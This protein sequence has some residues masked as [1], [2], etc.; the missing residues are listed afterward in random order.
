MNINF[1]QKTAVSAKE[2]FRH[3]EFDNILKCVHCGLCLESCPTYRELDDEKDSPRGRLYLMRGLWEGALE[4][5]QSVVEPLSRCVDCRACES[6]C[7]SGVPY[8]ELL[9]KT[10]GII[11][12]NTTQSLKERVL[13][14]LLLKGLFRST[15]LMITASYL[16][17][18]YA[19]T[20]LPKLIT[21]TFVGKLFP[22]SFVFQQHLLPNFSGKSFKLK[23]ADEVISSEVSEKIKPYTGPSGKSK[24]LKSKPRVGM[25]SG[26]IMDVSEAAIHES[27]LTLLH[28]IGCEVVVPGNQVCCGAIHVH[29]G[30]RETARELALKNLVAFEPRHLDAIITNAAGC[31]AQL[32]E[33]NLLFSK[34][35]SEAK[36]GVRSTTDW[37]DFEK[38]IIDVL[39]FLSRY[40]KLLEKLSWREDE[41]TV[42]YDAPCHLIHAQKVDENPRQ[43]LNNLPGVTLVPLKES[44]WCCGSGGI[45]NLVHPELSGAVLKRKTESIRQALT[46]N[47]KAT[48]IITGNPGCLYQIRA[49]IRS[50]NI[51]LHI[52]HPVVYLA[53]RLKKNES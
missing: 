18:I 2:L 36:K 29:S 23:Y 47:P 16:L 49:G 43:L 40:P 4:L 33:Y 11:F 37:Q 44:D 52:L 28:H 8:G 50:E 12:E 41:D 48:N 9:E 21:K 51:D 17:K 6:A 30:D 45:Y 5:K 19:I 31:G 10:R 1:S 24:R 3:A 15:G 35:T 32:K 34:E 42:L 27:T 26:C 46:T 22:R 7:P 53:G 38:K 13:R 14:R 25:F 20:G 39:E